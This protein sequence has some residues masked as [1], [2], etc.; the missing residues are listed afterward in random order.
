MAEER[1]QLIIENLMDFY[2]Y[3]REVDINREVLLGSGEVDFK[4]YKN[5]DEE[6]KILVEIKMASSPYLK[7]GYEKQLVKYMLSAKYKNAFYLIACFNDKEYNRAYNFVRGHVYTDAYTMY[8]NVF[9][10]DLRQRKTAS[11][12]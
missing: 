5:N 1:V 9:I 12:L 3:K 11:K 6:E 10:L 4:L 8:I 2:F 7:K